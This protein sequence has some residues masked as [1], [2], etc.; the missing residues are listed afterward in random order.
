MF[1]TWKS[2]WEIQSYSHCSS[3]CIPWSEWRVLWVLWELLNSGSPIIMKIK[4]LMITF[5]KGCIQ[6]WRSTLALARIMVI[7]WTLITESLAHS[8]QSITNH[9]TIMSVHQIDQIICFLFYFY[10]YSSN[11]TIQ[12]PIIQNQVIWPGR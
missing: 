8:Y 4:K 7:S 3:F 11:I 10:S 12:D 1:Y 5:A 2:F 9:P 6:P